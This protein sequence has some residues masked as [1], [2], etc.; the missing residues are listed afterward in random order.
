MLLYNEYSTNIVSPL[1]YLL[2]NKTKRIQ[3]LIEKIGDHKGFSWTVVTFYFL[4][5]ILCKFY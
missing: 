5:F 2:E 1:K 3:N 4:G